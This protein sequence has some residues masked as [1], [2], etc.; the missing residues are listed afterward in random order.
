VSQVLPLEELLCFALYS[1]SHAVTKAYRER[2]AAIGLTYPQYAALVA[3][4]EED[5]V[6]LRE[7][8]ERLCLDASTVTPLVKRL[9]TL[10]LVSRQRSTEDERRVHVHLTPA[11]RAL[12]GQLRDIQ[13]DVARQLP[14]TRDE[15]ILLR[16]LARRVAAS[17]GAPTAAWI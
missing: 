12:E 10:G 5:G 3:L 9:E 13:A 17:A 6:A 15:A 7:L 16:D 2:L 4:L 14:I 11:G 1:S 8:A